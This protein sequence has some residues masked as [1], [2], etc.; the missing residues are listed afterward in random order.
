[1]PGK[2]VAINGMLLRQ[3]YSG[4]EYS[5]LNLTRALAESGSESYDT[6]VPAGF[7]DATAPGSTV[8]TI[9]CPVPTPLRAMRILWEQLS[10][11]R[12]VARSGAACLHAPGYIAPLRCSVPVVLTIYDIIALIHPEWCKPLNHLHYARLLPPSARVAARIV[13]PSET[14]RRDVRERLQVPDEK[15]CTIPLGVESRYGVIEDPNEKELARKRMGLP[16]SFILYVGQLEPKKNLLGLLDAFRLIATESSLRHHLVIAGSR[17]WKVAE[18]E[19][20]IR[21]YGLAER[22]H[23]LGYTP[24]E[25]L[26]ALYNLAD[27]FAFPSLYEGFGLPPLEAMACGTPVVASN[28]GS[29]PEVVGAAAILADPY[30]SSAIAHAIQAGLNPGGERTA[31][32]EMGLRHASRFT[33]RAHAEA[34]DQVYRDVCGESR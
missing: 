24:Q 22:V 9:R 4:V 29:L 16:P 33:W 1:M 6:Y 19:H 21:A 15:I 5:I 23:L 28:A 12:L 8:N 27:L 11:P 17:G 32:I 30:D 14:T 20:R 10:L 34:M 31:R 13:V 2:K 25:D 7:A 18:L 26:P 3:P